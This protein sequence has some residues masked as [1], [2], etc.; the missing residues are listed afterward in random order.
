MVPPHKAARQPVPTADSRAETPGVN[1]LPEFPQWT[2]LGLRV[3]RLSLC[4]KHR[5]LL[6]LSKTLP[7]FCTRKGIRRQFPGVRKPRPL[8]LPSPSTRRCQPASLLAARGQGRVVMGWEQGQSWLWQALS[9]LQ[10]RAGDD[11]GDGDPTPAQRSRRSQTR[12]RGWK[13]GTSG[14]LPAKRQESCLHQPCFT[15]H[16]W[17][18]TD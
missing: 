11:G 17:G 9:M 8:R 15:M 3:S 13:A 18:R 2:W 16:P 1:T 12:P 5:L 6:K 14:L 4:L 7:W 10:S